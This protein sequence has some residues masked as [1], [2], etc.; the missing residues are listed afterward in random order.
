MPEATVV[1][2]PWPVPLFPHPDLSN[3][4]G[5]TVPFVG[6]VPVF[7]G[8]FPSSHKTRE[9][10]AVVETVGAKEGLYMG[11]LLYGLLDDRLPC[12][13]HFHDRYASICILCASA[14]FVLNTRSS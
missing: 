1:G 14:T 11:M 5:M 4:V 9:L 10:G 12:I 8:S 7:R 2:E 13:F 3:Q 6:T